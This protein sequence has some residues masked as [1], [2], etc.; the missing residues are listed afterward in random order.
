MP[1]RPSLLSLASEFGTC[2]FDLV[3]WNS[4]PLS[5][6]VD[7]EAA[8]EVV[9]KYDYHRFEGSTGRR[10]SRQFKTL[11]Q[12]ISHDP[13]TTLETLQQRLGDLDRA[14]LSSQRRQRKKIGAEK[15]Q[16]LKSKRKVARQEK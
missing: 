3:D 15:L 6:A 7:V 14:E 12:A 2:E 9:L 11:F 4:L 8:I 1:G 16:S 5:V 10:M 13:N